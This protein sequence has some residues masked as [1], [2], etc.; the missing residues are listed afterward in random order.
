[1]IKKVLVACLLLT[2]MGCQRLK[3]E[4]VERFWHPKQEQSELKES[5]KEVKERKEITQTLTNSDLQQLNVY[6]SHLSNSGFE[7]YNKENLNHDQ[8]LEF[9]LWLYLG[10]MVK[11][12]SKEIDGVYYSVFNY[13][14]FSHKISQY[15]DCELEKKGNDEWLFQDNNY[16]HP[17]LES[18]YPLNTVT[19]VDRIYDNGDNSF[20][21][22]GLVYRFES[23]MD[24]HIYEQYLQPK[25]TWS[26]SMESELIGNITTTLVY[27]DK[28][29]HYVI[30]D[31]QAKYY[32]G[33]YT[34]VLGAGKGKELTGTLK[35]SYCVS[36]KEIKKKSFFAELFS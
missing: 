8:L 32:N 17:L 31:Y 2:L 23:S 33:E 9:G 4:V 28:L 21:V 10:N 36:S 19:Q 13:D 16:Y 7:T 1:M 12:E 3:D 11:V 34:I 29:N 27:S 35:A 22:E 25:S 30:E 14:E 26:P 5:T 6:L 24:T 20:L 15:F 18:E